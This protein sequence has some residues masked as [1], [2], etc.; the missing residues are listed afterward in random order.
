MEKRKSIGIGV[1]VTLIV[2][3]TIAFIKPSVSAE[4]SGPKN[5]IP[6]GV[7]IDLTKDFYDTLRQEGAGGITYTNDPSALYL[8]QISISSR[9]MVE[10]N[11]QILR[12]QEQI[13]QALK[14]ALDKRK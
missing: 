6:E 14:A 13:L 8:K 1:L 5:N 4:G 11:L 10:T 3:A 12:Q 2:L 7:Y 9:F